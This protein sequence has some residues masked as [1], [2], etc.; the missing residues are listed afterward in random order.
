MRLV[1][2]LSFLEGTRRLRAS[3]FCGVSSC[4]VEGASLA[5]TS[6]TWTIADLSGSLLRQHTR[7]SLY[8]RVSLLAKGGSRAH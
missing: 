8:A 7:A 2:L 1:W 5:G 4:L 3:L 6:C